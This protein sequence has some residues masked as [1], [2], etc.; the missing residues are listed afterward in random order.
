MAEDNREIYRGE[1]FTGKRPGH[2]GSERIVEPTNAPKPD[3]NVPYCQA[4]KAQAQW[5]PSGKLW[6][7]HCNGAP[8]VP[9]LGRFAPIGSVAL[10]SFGA[11]AL[12]VWV[13]FF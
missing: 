13:L 5:L 2:G 11:L 7:P 9:S 4:C 3:P 1:G 12:A 6:C 10:A 8:G